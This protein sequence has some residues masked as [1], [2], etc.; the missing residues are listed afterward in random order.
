MSESNPNAGSS[1][2]Y[3]TVKSDSIKD[4]WPRT[5][6]FGNYKIFMSQTAN[7]NGKDEYVIYD[8]LR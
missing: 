1:K 7:V 8:S 6:D 4:G 2:I 3:S 5:S